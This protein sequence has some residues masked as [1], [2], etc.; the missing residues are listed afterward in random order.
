MLNKFCIEFQNLYGER[1]MSANVH[2]L[3]HLPGTVRELGPL[4]VYSCFHFEGLSGILKSLIHGTQKIDKQLFRQL[5]A[6]AD[7]CNSSPSSSMNN[8]INFMECF[9]RIYHQQNIRLHNRMK[10]NE[11][12]LLLGKPVTDVLT[13]D[14]KQYLYSH[15]IIDFFRVKRYLQVIINDVHYYGFKWY[16]SCVKTKNNSVIVYC[17]NY[18]KLEFGIIQSFLVCEVPPSHLVFCILSPLIRNIDIFSITHQY[19][20]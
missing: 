6:A 7:G 5:P 20:M 12:L 9:K 10:L 2:L 13:E 1:Y 15:G 14:E 17:D 19:R 8:S 16:R 3:L 11:D 4:W 18:N